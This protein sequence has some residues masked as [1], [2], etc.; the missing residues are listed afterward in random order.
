VDE[1]LRNGSLGMGGLLGG[2]RNKLRRGKEKIFMTGKK[3]HKKRRSSRHVSI[4]G[5]EHKTHQERKTRVHPTSAPTG[6]R[7]KK[8]APPSLAITIPRTEFENATGKQKEPRFAYR[9]I[10]L[11]KRAGSDS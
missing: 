3:A 10:K 1:I 9:F 8:E 4:G 7:H 6:L 5:E 2:N 11:E